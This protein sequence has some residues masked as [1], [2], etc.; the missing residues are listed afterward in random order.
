M[1][2]HGCI[3]YSTSLLNFYDVEDMTDIVLNMV[4]YGAAPHYVFTWEESSEMKKTALNRY[5]AT[6]YEVWKGEAVE[7]YEQVN[8][9]LKHVSGAQMIGHE[10][11]EE[12]VR[13]V[14]YDNGVTIYLNYND[15][16]KTAD[17]VEILPGSY[18][19]EG[20]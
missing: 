9:A 14:S 10:I 7:I 16:V 18:R 8:E 13:K 6:T 12:G 3:D 19:M 20:N 4:E 15:E 11:L 17:G 2:I 1:I 5:Y